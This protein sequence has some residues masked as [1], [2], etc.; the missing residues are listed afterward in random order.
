VFVDY[1]NT[2]QALRHAGHQIDLVA[3]RDYLAEGRQLIEVLVYI[4]T[5]PQPE[6]HRGDQLALDRLRRNGFLI[7][8]KVGKLLPNG[9]LRCHL[10][11]EIALDVQDFIT[12]AHPD[13]VVLVT[14]S[15]AMTPLVQ[16]LRLHGIRVEV[17][18]TSASVSP[19]LRA[20]A[21]GFVDLTQTGRRVD[22]L[23]LPDLA[24]NPDQEPVIEPDLA[25]E[26]AIPDLLPRD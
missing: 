18:S 22:N 11:L 1:G 26:E 14:G 4:A 5:H 15:G 20:M 7:R 9:Q 13:I 12:Y 19:S 6:R 23:P 8:S 16:R 24:P 17:A 25:E 2:L 21:N 3:L 10:D